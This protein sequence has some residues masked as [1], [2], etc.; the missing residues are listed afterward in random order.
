MSKLGIIVSSARPNRVGAHVSR[1]IAEAAARSWEIDLINLGEVALPYFDEPASPKQGKPYTTPHSRSWSERVRSLDAVVFVT[2]EYNGSYPGSLK[3]AVDYL[4]S[5]WADLPV[6]VVGYGWGGGSGAIAD[7]E[8]LMRRLQADLVGSVAL[9]FRQDL[10]T[11]GNLFVG[12]ERA[13]AL[14]DALRTLDRQVATV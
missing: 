12:P 6:A 1:W 14:Q 4:Y 13:A 3:N 9:T 2:P 11:E 5:E 10:D 8:R 7:V